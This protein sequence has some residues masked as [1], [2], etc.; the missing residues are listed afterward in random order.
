M[1]KTYKEAALPVETDRF[2]V[3][4]FKSTDSSTDFCGN[5]E[6]VTRM[7]HI[8]SCQASLRSISFQHI[9]LHRL[10]PACHDC[11][12]SKVVLS[13]SLP[14]SF[15]YFH[16]YCTSLGLQPGEACNVQDS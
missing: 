5:K 15:S 3:F 16:L 8:Q 12:D 9:E 1:D 11:C 10:S 13:H 14:L 4:L 7:L 6:F 2:Y